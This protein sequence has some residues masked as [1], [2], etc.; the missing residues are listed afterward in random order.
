MHHTTWAFIGVIVLVTVIIY[1][2]FALDHGT[3]KLNRLRDE[4][5]PRGALPL[6]V[7][8]PEFTQ[9]FQRR[10]RTENRAVALSL[11]LFSVIAI[12]TFNGFHTVPFLIPF[13]LMLVLSSQAIANVIDRH[14]EI[15]QASRSEVRYSRSRYPSLTDY[16]AAKYAVAFWAV[17]ILFESE[18]LSLNRAYALS[19]A[20]QITALILMPILCAL[21][22]L[23][24]MWIARQPVYANSEADLRWEDK[25][26]ANDV[27]FLPL[28]AFLAS[29]L[30]LLTS[31][32]PEI[33]LKNVWPFL[34][35]AGTAMLAQTAIT[36]AAARHAARHLWPDPEYLST[37]SGTH[38]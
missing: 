6:P 36:L 28:Y 19:N 14:R 22:W 2:G 34:L 12:G 27:Q 26:I 29:T 17:L 15:R 32:D 20:I 25:L 13:A 16:F 38:P 31:L 35:P 1:A 37:A 5:V 7:I 8:T 24:S 21:T 4:I 11:V 23:V 3:T 33:V 10:T 30:T 18:Y 9:R